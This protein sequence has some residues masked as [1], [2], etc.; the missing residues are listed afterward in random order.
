MKASLAEVNQFTGNCFRIVRIVS[1]NNFVCPKTRLGDIL[2]VDLCPIMVSC[3]LALY[4]S[5]LVLLM[6]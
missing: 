5:L 4:L 6:Y 3:F 1:K 2:S